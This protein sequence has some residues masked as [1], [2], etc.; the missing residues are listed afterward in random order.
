MSKASGFPDR[1]GRGGGGGGVQPLIV[2]TS[3]DS[4]VYRPVFLD[5]MVIF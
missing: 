1:E 3:V 2:C 5:E 4:L